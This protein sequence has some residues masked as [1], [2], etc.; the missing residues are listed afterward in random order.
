[1]LIRRV[2]LE[3]FGL[4]AGR[5][6]FDLSPRDRYK[7]TRPIILFGGKNGAGKT[8]L[9]EAVRLALYGRTALGPRV[10]QVDYDGYLRGR[11]HRTRGEAMPPATHAAVA[12]EFEYVR[13]GEAAKTYIVERRWR[14]RGAKG[15]GRAVHSPG[16]GA[17]DPRL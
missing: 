12:L 5:Q 6:E 16:R 11:I 4:Y 2:I 13:L 3:N 1:M 9:L 8:S 14:A 17:A 15:R 7:R 10:R